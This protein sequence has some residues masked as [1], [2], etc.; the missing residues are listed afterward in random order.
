MLLR[1]YHRNTFKSTSRLLKIIKIGQVHSKT[2]RQY[3]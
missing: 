2:F 3:K 1:Y